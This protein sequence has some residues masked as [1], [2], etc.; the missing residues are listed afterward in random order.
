VADAIL[1]A[2]RAPI[3]VDGK[4]LEIRASIGI[5]VPDNGASVADLLHRADLAMYAAKRRGTH[6]AQLYDPD[7]VAESL[8][9]ARS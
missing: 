8:Q 5:A 4:M 3:T 2:V 9:V 7:V 6:D 1:A